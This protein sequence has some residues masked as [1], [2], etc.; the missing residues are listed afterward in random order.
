MQ[1]WI[2]HSVFPERFV[3][4]CCNFCFKPRPFV[5]RIHFFIHLKFGRMPDIINSP[6]NNSSIMA[7]HHVIVAVTYHTVYS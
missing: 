1:A 3:I 6:M 2:N 4:I 7:F 5:I